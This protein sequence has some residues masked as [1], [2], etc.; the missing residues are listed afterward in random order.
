MG[1]FLL[2]NERK[3]E[4]GNNLQYI[5]F[6]ISDHVIDA[7]RKKYKDEKRL[8]F[9]QAD[10]YS[11]PVPAVDIVMVREAYFHV[12]FETIKESL[13]KISRS[14]SKWLFTSTF[15]AT[16]QDVTKQIWFEGRYLNME[17]DPINLKEPHLR[18]PERNPK[19]HYMALWK[20]PLEGYE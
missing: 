15:N 12:P 14:G 2:Q 8:S 11:A 20:L 16:N 13:K 18:F 1:R 17:A 10:L 6:D 9:H 7:H 4:R 19:A 3:S 5:G